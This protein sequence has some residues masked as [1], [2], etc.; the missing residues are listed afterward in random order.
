MFSFPRLLA[1]AFLSLLSI[2]ARAGKT[3]GFQGQTAAPATQQGSKVEQ[4][5]EAKRLDEQVNKL[6]SESNFE[7]ALKPA[8]QSLTLRKAALPSDDPL[9]AESLLIWPCCTSG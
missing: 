8:E 3:N 1:V 7:Q 6:F 5:S 4:L 2:H 9:V